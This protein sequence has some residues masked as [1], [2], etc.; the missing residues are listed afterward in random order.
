MIG[1]TLPLDQGV[2]GEV[3]KADETGQ[4][5]C[6]CVYIPSVVKDPRIVYFQWPKLGALL[7]IP[8]VYKSCLFEA[9]LDAGIDE[10][11]KY[12]KNVEEQQLEREQK[13]LEYQEKIRVAEEKDEDVEALKEEWNNISSEWVD[14]KEADFL[15]KSREFVVCFDTLGQ[16]KEITEE[17]QEYFKKYVSLFAEKWEQK[18]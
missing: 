9:A 11:I 18:V 17:E 7:V 5:A 4:M 2:T 14:S 1:K 13:R 12:L 6:S 15:V 3:F 10:R 8:L 16:D